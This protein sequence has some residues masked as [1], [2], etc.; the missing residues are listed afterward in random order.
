MFEE[1]LTEKQYLCTDVTKKIVD[2]HRIALV[3][4][5]VYRRCDKAV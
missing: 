5:T 3:C 4:R 2:C 1:F